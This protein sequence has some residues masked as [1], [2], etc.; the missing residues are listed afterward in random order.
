MLKNALVACTVSLIAV[1]AWGMTARW[2]SGATASAIAL[3]LITVGF[4]GALLGRR[5]AQSPPVGGNPIDPSKEMA[6]WLLGFV[7][8]SIAGGL[9]A[10]GIFARWKAEAV[11]PCSVLL[12]A[13]LVGGLLGF[14]FGVPRSRS[15]SATASTSQDLASKIDANTNLE[16]ISDWLTTVLVGVSLVQF[17]AI[18]DFIVDFSTSLAANMGTEPGDGTATFVGG[19]MIGGFGVGFISGWLFCRLLLGA[20]MKKVD[21]S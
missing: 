5:V 10:C 1:I 11:V 19:V 9:V 20:A 6:Y 8:V 3:G 12:S 14:I 15:H 18:G 13:T 4:V 2:P 21:E 16:K 17:R 7:V